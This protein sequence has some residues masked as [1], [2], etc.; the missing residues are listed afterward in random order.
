METGCGGG[1][2]ECHWLALLRTRY[3]YASARKQLDAPISAAPQPPPEHR[4]HRALP[5]KCRS[6]MRC[7]QVIAEQNV[8]TLP[9]HG[10]RRG[11]VQ[12]SQLLD[13]G[14]RELCALL[15]AT[16]DRQSRGTATDQ[17]DLLHSRRPIRS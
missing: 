2:A 9:R 8:A 16:F 10:H 13:L 5:L 7:A 11:S 12:P 17:A 14:C 6:P 3:E 4:H 15:T 1:S